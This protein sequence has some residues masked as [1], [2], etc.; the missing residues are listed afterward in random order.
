[1]NICEL[2]LDIDLLI[3]TIFI[4]ANYSSAIFFFITEKVRTILTVKG[5]LS[6]RDGLM[7]FV[8]TA[9]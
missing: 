9:I 3:Y 1:M 4:I 7:I 5:W 2:T 8:I 6:F